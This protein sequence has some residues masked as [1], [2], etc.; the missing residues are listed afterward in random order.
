MLLIFVL[1][2]NC[3]FVPGFDFCC[4]FHPIMASE[5]SQL[6][7]CDSQ[8]QEDD[9]N[10]KQEVEVDPW[11]S[12][13]SGPNCSRC[14]DKLVKPNELKFGVCQECYHDPLRWER[15]HDPDPLTQRF[16]APSQSTSRATFTIPAST[17]S[18]S[19]TSSK[20]QPPERRDWRNGIGS[21]PWPDSVKPVD[22]PE[23]DNKEP[24]AKRKRQ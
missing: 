1:C 2:L 23:S 17:L 11:A 22:R 7:L 10:G 16:M 14:G 3:R 5:A 21:E 18:S 4:F 9:N 8:E 20:A 12:L 19:S 6:Q 13:F 24:P 15:A